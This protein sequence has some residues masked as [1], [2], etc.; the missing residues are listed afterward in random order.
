MKGWKMLY[1]GS[2]AEVVVVQFDTSTMDTIN[3][4]ESTAI[5]ITVVMAL[6]AIT[7]AIIRRGIP[8]NKP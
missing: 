5:T 2:L 3:G 7:C 8:K 6:T 1:F 4:L